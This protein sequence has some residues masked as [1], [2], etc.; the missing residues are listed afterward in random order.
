M[1]HAVVKPVST[2]D[3]HGF[4]IPQGYYLHRGHAWV[5]IEEDREVRVGMDDFALRLLG[6]PDA[7]V[8]P[9]WAR[10]T[11]RNKAQIT[12]NRGKITPVYCHRSAVW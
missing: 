11:T 4:K 5:K 9:W 3:I 10:A 7:I 2:L 6:P 8:S 1:V 12:L